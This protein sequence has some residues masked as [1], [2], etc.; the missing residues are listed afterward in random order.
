MKKEIGL[1]LLTVSLLSIV[2][3]TCMLDVYMINQDPYPAVPGEYVKLVF[4]VDGL[5]NKDCEEVMVE[6]VPNY[7]IVLDPNS[8]TKVSA[9]SGTFVRDFGSHLIVPYRVRIDEDAVEGD[10]PIDVKVSYGDILASQKS[11]IISQFNLTVE[12]LKADFEIT[13]KDYSPSSN[14]LTFEILNIGE[15]DIEALTLE[16]P[17]QENIN[18]KGSYRNIV[19]DLDS[20]DYTTA[21][22][23][24]VPKKGEINIK[25][26][27]TD[28]IHER[29]TLEKTVMFNPE[30]FEGRNSSQGGTSIWTWIIILIVV[31][32]VI[33]WL[34]K[35]HKR[36]KQAH[37]R[38]KH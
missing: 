9:N 34:Y 22:F 20:S 21:D 15:S 1:L 19:G 17:E 14:T 10:N 24:A 33:Y 36:K 27:Y 11:T 16:I 23:E 35:R 4:Q 12:D 31:V 30:Y 38:N 2:S 26:L 25:I 8:T 29:R 18:V 3:A 6:L 13:I 32:V 37:S 5:E 28:S 7:P